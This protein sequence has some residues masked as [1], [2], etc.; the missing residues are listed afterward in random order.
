MDHAWSMAH[1]NF[2]SSLSDEELNALTGHAKR[3]SYKKNQQIFSAGDN[4]KVIYIVAS[5]CIKLY[6]LSPGGKEIILWFSFPGELFGIAETVRGVEREIFA[7]ANIDS[8]VLV[9]SEGDFVEFLRSHPEAAMRAIGILSARL[10]TV[11]FSYADLAADDVE[12][13][14]VKLLLRFAAGSLPTPCMMPKSSE[15]ICVNIDLTHT[16]L[17]NLI[18]ATRQTVNS[19]LAGFRRAG[20]VDLVDRHI[21]IIDPDGLSQLLEG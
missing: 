13:R 12:T 9:L 8:Q 17:G 19:T 16:D 5:G 2:L 1:A 7:S 14:L 10:R 18:G 3:N 20:L 4:A 6:Q 11:G 21:H 15:E